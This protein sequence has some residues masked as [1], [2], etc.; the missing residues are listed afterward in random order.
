LTRDD[1]VE[2]WVFEWVTVNGIEIPEHCSGSEL[3]FFFEQQ[4]N[5]ASMEMK[6]KQI[7]EK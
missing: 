4:I 7:I 6:A 1:D 2:Q 5:K 3:L